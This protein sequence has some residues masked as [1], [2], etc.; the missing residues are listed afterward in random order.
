MF[1]RRH[2]LSLASSLL[3]APLLAGEAARADEEFPTDRVTVEGL[4]VPASGTRILGQGTMAKD[5]PHPTQVY[6]V[7][8]SAD[9]PEG[10]LDLMVLGCNG[11]VLALEPLRWRGP[12]GEILHTRPTL[13]SDWRHLRLERDASVPRGRTH[14]HESWTDYLLW[15]DGGVMRNDPVRTPLPGTLQAA[16]APTRAA[17]AGLI[18]VGLHGV[19]PAL[20]RDCPLPDFGL[21]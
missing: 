20:L 1:S 21:G 19:P 14:Y 16:L 2:L 5:T 8:F 7:G 12:H 17:M 11:W 3:A 9:P 4:D 6:L 18:S 13:I 15:T 10:E